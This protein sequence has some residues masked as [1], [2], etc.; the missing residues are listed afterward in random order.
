M[1]Y[2][3]FDPPPHVTVRV[4][5]TFDG[6]SPKFY[7]HWCS[8]FVKSRACMA[9]ILIGTGGFLDQSTVLSPFDRLQVKEGVYN[10]LC[11]LCHLKSFKGLRDRKR[12]ISAPSA[13]SHSSPPSAT[14]GHSGTNI[15]CPLAPLA[16]LQM[17]IEPF[18]ALT[19]CQPMARWP[20]SGCIMVHSV[21]LKNLLSTQAF[22]LSFHI[23]Q[24]SLESSSPRLKC[25]LQ[26]R[27]K[28]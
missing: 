18:V 14:L 24:L 23:A 7:N 9:S 6:R 1:Q 16:R 19:L 11:I 27:M 2:A 20:N 3:R 28:V 8:G 5:P 22:T 26:Q 4:R 21:L 17:A 25:L 13:S 15:Y 12:K 10:L